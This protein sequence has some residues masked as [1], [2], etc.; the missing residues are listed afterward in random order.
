MLVFKRLVTLYVTLRLRVYH[1]KSSGPIGCIVG[2]VASEPTGRDCDLQVRCFDSHKAAVTG[3]SFDDAA[4]HIGSC[5]D[6]GSVVV[7]ECRETA[8]CGFAPC[9]L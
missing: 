6:D 8:L 4:E 9:A 5:S 2:D 1:Q 3:L 7:S